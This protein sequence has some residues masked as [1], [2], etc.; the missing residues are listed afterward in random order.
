MCRLQNDVLLDISPVSVCAR[1]KVFF[2]G[3]RESV[4]GCECE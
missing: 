2:E 1:K 3:E 4:C